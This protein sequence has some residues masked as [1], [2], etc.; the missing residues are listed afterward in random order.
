M[1]HGATNLL[2]HEKATFQYLRQH[3][4][5]GGNEV[6]TGAAGRGCVHVDCFC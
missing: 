6:S 3:S 1:Y 4:V 2:Q 5:E